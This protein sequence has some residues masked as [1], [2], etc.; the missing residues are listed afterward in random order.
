MSETIPEGRVYGVFV[1]SHRL[2]WIL[3][4]ITIRRLR[5][6]IPS[7][8]QGLQQSWRLPLHGQQ[9]QKTIQRGYICT[10]KSD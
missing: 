8:S 6:S 1:P 3:H 5:C 7:M 9:R 4:F 10:S 2:R